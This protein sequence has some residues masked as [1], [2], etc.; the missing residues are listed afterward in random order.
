MLKLE[1]NTN[2]LMITSANIV[3]IK[4]IEDGYAFITYSSDNNHRYIY[5]SPVI[6][7]HQISSST[8]VYRLEQKGTH[9]Q[10]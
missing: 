1:P 2:Y 4:N 6:P 3:L 10:T 9:G 7:K 8:P 5:H